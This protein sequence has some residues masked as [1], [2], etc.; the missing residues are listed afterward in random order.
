MESGTVKWFNSTKGYGF[1]TREQGDDVFVHYKAIQG[2]GY[3][4][5]EEGEKVEFEVT[6]GAKGPQAVNVVKVSAS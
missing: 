4:S 3:K 2:E 5:L 1:I 6:D